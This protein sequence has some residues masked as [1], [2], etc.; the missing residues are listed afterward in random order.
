MKK[1]IAV[2]GTITLSV[3]LLAG[4]SG[5]EK[6]SNTTPSQTP[7]ETVRPEVPASN[8]ASAPVEKPLAGES[9]NTWTPIMISQEDN[10]KTIGLNVEQIG[11]FIDLPANDKLNNITVESNNPKVVKTLQNNDYGDVQTNA[12]IQGLEIGTAKI[13]VWDG[14]P[15]SNGAVVVLEF[16]V[17]VSAPLNVDLTK[18]TDNQLAGADPASWAPINVDKGL[19]D[20]RLVPRQSAVFTD[21][22]MLDGSTYTVISSDTKVAEPSN[23]EDNPMLGFHAIGTGTATV[24]VINANGDIVQTV[25]VSVQD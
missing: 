21:R 19:V 8:V 25:G 10:N 24:A 11:I 16:A 1:V 22:T 9:P 13:T 2:I 18:P 3:T 17:K 15:D 6:D 12:G 23:S 7:V 20:V 4:C 14:T 5:N